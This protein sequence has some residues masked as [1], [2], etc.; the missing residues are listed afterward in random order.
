MRQ[1]FSAKER[2]VFSGIAEILNL[3]MNEAEYLF[4]ALR[5]ISIDDRYEQ[6][7]ESSSQSV[8]VENNQPNWYLQ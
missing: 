1:R 4:H 8:C 6:I 5:E 7:K 3:S 2:K